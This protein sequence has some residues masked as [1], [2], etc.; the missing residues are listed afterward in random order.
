MK[1]FS[2][3]RQSLLLYFCQ[4]RSHLIRAKL[5]SQCSLTSLQ[6]STILCRLLSPDPLLRSVNYLMQFSCESEMAW[7]AHSHPRK[8]HEDIPMIGWGGQEVMASSFY[9]T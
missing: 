6:V 2:V 1:G 5:P 8:F 3:L 9:N 7:R 4:E